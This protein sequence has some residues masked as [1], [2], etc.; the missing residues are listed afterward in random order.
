MN[1]DGTKKKKLFTLKQIQGTIAS[2]RLTSLLPDE[3]NYVMVAINDRRG[4]ISD[5]YKMNVFNGSRKRT[6][7]GPLQFFFLTH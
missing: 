3:P 5:Y 6:A 2:P 7:M 4:A 1:I